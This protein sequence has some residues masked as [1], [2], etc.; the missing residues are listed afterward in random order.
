MRLVQH[1]DQKS[2]P[3]NALYDQVKRCSTLV[4]RSG[5]VTVKVLQSNL[6]L[7]FYEISH[8][9][10]PAAYFTIRHSASIGVALGVHSRTAPFQIVSPAT[11]WCE[12]EER[13]RT[14][15]GVIMLDRYIN[16]GTGSNVF[17]CADARPG[18]LLPMDEASWDLGEP[19]LVQSLAVSS[20]TDIAASPFTR[21]SQAAHLLS[22]ILK[23]ISET[24]DD[25]QIYY[26]EAEQLHFILSSFGAAL[27]QES[28][29]C[30]NSTAR[31]PLLTAVGI[32]FSTKMALYDHY[33]CAEVDMNGG[34]GT[35]AQLT[36]QY[37]ALKGIKSAVSDIH[38]LAHA[39]ISMTDGGTGVR[40]ISPLVCNCLYAA[41]MYL[42]WHVRESPRVEK[43]VQFDLIMKALRRMGTVWW[44]A[45]KFTHFGDYVVGTAS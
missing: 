3:E 23:H 21:A 8:A 29:Y 6:L 36:M 38:S 45:S 32:C 39:L 4:E 15:W 11:S 43:K 30:E 24:H 10:Y 13:R 17:A 14:W 5:I 37:M 26:K 33:S 16:I 19:A 44:I 34:V 41:G 12:L 35:D 18:D 25:Y 20:S 42:Y 22:R 9:I 40:S 2:S 27:T 1:S 28:D 7:A 31:L